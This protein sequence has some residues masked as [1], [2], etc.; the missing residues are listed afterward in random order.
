MNAR[1]TLKSTLS[2]AARRR[3]HTKPE[4]RVSWSSESGFGRTATGKKQKGTGFRGHLD[5]HLTDRAGGLNVYL[6]RHLG[7]LRASVRRW[8][9]GGKKFSIRHQVAVRCC[10]PPCV[11]FRPPPCPK[12]GE[13]TCPWAWLTDGAKC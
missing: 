5:A 1:L 12:K 11:I 10:A 3:C 4:P 2:C 8:R 6:E 13:F 9:G 7:T